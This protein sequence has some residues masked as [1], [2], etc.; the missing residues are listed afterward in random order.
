VEDSAD[1]NP[2]STP[3][4]VTA[5]VLVD[6]TIDVGWDAST[7]NVGV[8]E[9]RVLRNL[10]EVALVPGDE[11]STNVDLGDG[12]HWIQVQALDAAGNESFRTA[13]VQVDVAG[14]EPD[15]SP[16]STP[17]NVK[18]VVQP[19]DSILVTWTA[20]SDNVG[21]TEYVVLRNLVEVGTVPG[22]EVQSV[23]ESLGPGDHY[24]QVKAL[25][26][27]GNES[28]RSAPVMVTI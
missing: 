16:P 9:Y 15:T 26:A 5:T 13:P 1:T 14:N 21:V 2:P 12:T 27:A 8:T 11:T 17:G 22:T 23:I 20:S 24:M 4:N 25:D 19:D 28:F 18:A 10:V 7:D 6:D 3:A